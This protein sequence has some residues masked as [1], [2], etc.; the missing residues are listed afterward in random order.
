M[1]AELQCPP[2][3]YTLLAIAL[4][5][6]NTHAAAHILLCVAADNIAA[7]ERLTSDTTPAQATARRT[8]GQ[9]ERI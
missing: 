5:S 9:S 2:T 4:A 8:A 1:S 7:K 3:P 6:R